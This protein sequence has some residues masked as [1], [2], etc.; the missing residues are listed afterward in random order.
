MQCRQIWAAWL[1]LVTG[2]CCVNFATAAS[3]LNMREEGETGQPGKP[4]RDDAVI[5]RTGFFRPRSGPSQAAAARVPLS[6][7]RAE[8]R[9]P[10]RKVL[11]KPT[12]FTQGP[13]ETFTCCPCL[14][15]WLLGHPDQAVHLWRRLGARC[16]DIQN[17]GDGVFGWSDGQGSDVR[18][19]TVLCSTDM[20]IWYAEG[21]VRAAG[22]LPLVPV[23]AVVAL[24]HRE[25]RSDNGRTLI[26][27]QADLFLYTDS[28]TAA[29]VA[30]LMRPTAPRMAEQCAGQIQMFYSALAWYLD[31]H[32]IKAEAMLS[33][34]LPADAPEWHELRQR[35]KSPHLAGS[36]PPATIPHGGG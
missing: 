12:L 25:H 30:R 1:A 7:L 11:E 18:W 10:I 24:Y 16:M 23:R 20:R 9:E 27:H 13:A 28:K 2:V 26:Q 5:V 19:K 22:I 6:E 31:Q 14:Y 8:V 29:L 4:A 32:P 35:S 21:N 36:I 3:Q 17:R 33:G 34:I 15:Q